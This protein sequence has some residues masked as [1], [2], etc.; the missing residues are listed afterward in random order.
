MNGLY[1]HVS[2]Y[3]EGIKKGN[4]DLQRT[5]KAP[6]IQQFENTNGFF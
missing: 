3:T 1:L 6:D 4:N 2:L 5:L